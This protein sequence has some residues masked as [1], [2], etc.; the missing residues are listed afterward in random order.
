MKKQIEILRK[1]REQKQK[2]ASDNK[3][4]KKTKKAEVKKEEKKLVQSENKKH[5]EDDIVQ[6]PNESQANAHN[7]K[8]GEDTR[9]PTC[10][11]SFSNDWI[12]DI[13]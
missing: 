6:K 11:L 13:D 3:S 4:S 10:F 1:K 5:D 2:N 8:A 9:T 12:Y 7:N